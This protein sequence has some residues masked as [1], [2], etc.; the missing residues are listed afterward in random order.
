[1]KEPLGLPS[2]AMSPMRFTASLRKDE[3]A[4][5]VGPDGRAGEKAGDKENKTGGL[6]EGRRDVYVFGERYC[7]TAPTLKTALKSQTHQCRA[8]LPTN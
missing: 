7:A 6:T 1:M 4:K 2:S 3:T 8:E 5:S